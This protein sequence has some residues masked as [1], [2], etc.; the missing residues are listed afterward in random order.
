MQAVESP[1]ICT[2]IGSVC[3]KHKAYKYLD[4]KVQK[5]YVS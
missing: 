5:N 2:L 1:K 3:P 4:E